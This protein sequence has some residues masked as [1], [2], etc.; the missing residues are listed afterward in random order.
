MA[1]LVAI[2]YPSETQ[3]A[4]VLEPLRR[5]QKGRVLDLEDACVV[6][7][8]RA[9]KVTLHQTLNTTAIGALAGAFWGSLVGLL[10]LAPLGGAAVGAA[11][12]ALSGHF[13]DYGIDDG[14][15]KGLAQDMAPG[16]SAV[17]LLVRRAT[18]DRVGPDLA[19]LGGRILYTSVSPEME[20][21][22]EEY[23]AAAALNAPVPRPGTAADPP[24]RE[25]SSLAADATRT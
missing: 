5:L 2:V 24:V 19:K 25:R 17:F 18:L 6:V 12:G 4:Q 14:F 13:T 23:L 15:M 21:K 1:H 9:G 11:A 16:S 3:A 8:D 22:F 10:F 7:K 20:R